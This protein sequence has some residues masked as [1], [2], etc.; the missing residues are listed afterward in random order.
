[1][2]DRYDGCYNCAERDD[3]ACPEFPNGIKGDGPCEKHKLMDS[4]RHGRQA[5]QAYRESL[6]GET[7]GRQTHST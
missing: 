4:F 7:H 1:M 5:E 3:R 2:T 6:K